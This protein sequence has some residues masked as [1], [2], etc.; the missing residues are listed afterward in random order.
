MNLTKNTN[1]VTV[2]TA[3]NGPKLEVVTT[4]SSNVAQQEQIVVVAP[5]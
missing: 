4:N 2:T 3:Q 5:G 1:A